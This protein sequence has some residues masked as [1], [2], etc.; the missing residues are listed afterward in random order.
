MTDKAIEQL[1]YP[2][3]AGSYE[4]HKKMPDF[5]YIRKELLRNGVNRKLLWTE[6][7]EECRANG[8]DPLMYSQFCFHIQQNEQKRNATMHIPRKPGQ[9]VEVDGKPCGFAA[10]S[11][12]LLGKT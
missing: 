12:P 8:D 7:L 9:Q 3:K 1:M 2:D 5:D 6:Y 11:G 10:A 4:T